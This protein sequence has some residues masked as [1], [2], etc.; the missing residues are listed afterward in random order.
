MGEGVERNESSGGAIIAAD[1]IDGVDHQRMKLTPGDDGIDEGDVSKTNPLPV[2]ERWKPLEW[3]ATPN[4]LDSVSIAGSESADI[5]CEGKTTV[6]LKI[7]Y[8]G[9]DVTAP[10]WVVFKDTNSR[11]RYTVKRTSAN[12]GEQADIQE[13][14]YYHGEG[15]TVKVKGAKSFRVVLADTPSN[16]GAISVWAGAV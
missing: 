6:E 15:L 8:S 13:T 11:R 10:L 3:D 2:A 9:V 1:R 7:E 12:S 5:D 4:A 16:S 14:G